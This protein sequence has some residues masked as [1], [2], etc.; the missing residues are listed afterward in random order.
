MFPYPSGAGLHVGHLKGYVPTDIIARF[1]KLSGFDV[2]HPIGWDA[3][4]LPA[5]HYAIST[6]NHPE[7][8]TKKN[9][10]IF[11]EQLQ[12]MGFNYDYNKE[13]N[14]TDP[15]YY[16][17]TQWIFSKLFEEGLAEIKDIEV[18]WC[19]ELHTVLANEEVLIVDG[20]MVS[21]RGQFPVVKK[22]MRQWVLK[23]TK[24]ADKL[25]DGLNDV[26][27]PESL[28]SIQRN[29]IG[30]S[31][32]ALVKFKT[33]SGIEFEVF[34]TRPD[35]IYGVTFLS[36]APENAIVS[37]LT[38]SEY[39][40]QVAEYV[41]ATKSKTD[42][43]RKDLQKDKTGVFTGSYVIN[44]ISNEKIP[45][46]VADYV[47]NS[48][49]TGIVMGVPGHDQR[50]YEFAQKYH[51][52]VKFI[53]ET[54]DKTKANEE[55]GK[56]INSRLINGKNIK[57]SSNIIIKYLEEHRL[58]HKH[59]SY[60]LN[61]WIFSRQRYWGEPFPIIFD[62][63]Q[64][65]HLIK[66][67]PIALPQTEHIKPTK[68]GESPLANLTEW[69]N[70]E[71]DGK[72]YRRETNTMPQWA[73]SCWYYL[74]YLMKETNGEYLPLDDPKT[75]ELF[76]KWL[77]VDLYVG[78]QEHAVLHLLYSRFWH[79]FLYDI[80]V[81]PTK[82]PFQLLINQGMILGPDGEKMSK[83]RGNVI[84]P[85]E[86]IVTHGADALR[87]HLAFMGPLTASLPWSDDGLNGAR[88]WLDRVYRLFIESNIEFTDGDVDSKLD[89]AF[90]KFI[91]QAT[92]DINAYGFNTAISQMMIYINE[93][94]AHKVLSKKHMCDFIIVLS[95]FAPH[96]AEEIWHEV[97]KQRD[98]VTNQTW[99]KYDE[100]KTIDAIIT[101]PIQENGKLRATINIKKDAS[102]AEV[103]KLACVEPKV[104][105]FIDGRKP[106]KV[107]Y[108]K[109]KILNF[110]F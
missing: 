34:T 44:P 69:L 54:Q 46:Y 100:S 101:L 53:I 102:Q 94:Y 42:L 2:L 10:N 27:W 41:D 29:W 85:N 1:K 52:P 82:E 109:N 77:P 106:K 66:E 38:T 15:N 72:H 28:K 26:D 108:V 47:L 25:L 43:N 87:I 64:K 22:P 107:I 97:L 35:T 84:N 76:K 92:Q 71:I 49:A 103:E 20:K 57:E 16:K 13:V 7:D 8:F 3:F 67:L 74:A 37:K 55:D 83:S 51:L 11:R 96:L 65:P 70:V 36:I 5:E 86:L 80:G 88:K 30:R 56:H 6:G 89:I 14:T 19:E 9:I 50:D 59:V 75:K 110:I 81:V 60:K 24:Y 91:K 90:H 93:C 12:K 17:W 45:V 99:P 18:N 105:K 33:I 32:G 58:G 63:K 79:R 62:D 73:G 21:E 68:S 61:D 104:V 95:C 40:K 4:G 23:I 31:I 39:K 98:S 48:Y 78:G